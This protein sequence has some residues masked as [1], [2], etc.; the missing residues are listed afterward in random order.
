MEKKIYKNLES[1]DPIKKV[2]NE[3]SE[4]LNDKE[5]TINTS[6]IPEILGAV[7]GAGVGTGIGIGIVSTAGVAGLSAAGISSGLAAAGSVIGGGMAAGIFVAA[8]P[9]AILAVGGYGI[10]AHQKKKRLMQAKESLLQEA[11]KKHDAIIR[12]LKKQV[13]LSKERLEYLNSLNI[14]LQNAISNLQSD[15]A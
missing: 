9:V 10:I 6:S 7:I 14:L 3:V 5:R 12:E 13:D 4:A 8:A 11:I 15:I 2:I 1:L